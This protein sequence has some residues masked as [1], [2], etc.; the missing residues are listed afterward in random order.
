MSRLDCN[1]KLQVSTS[2]PLCLLVE[3]LMQGNDVASKRR[4]TRSRI[5]ST[6]PRV[7]RITTSRNELSNIARV[8]VQL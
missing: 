4:T 3:V 6:M 5:E 7:V 1:L 2:V 8:S